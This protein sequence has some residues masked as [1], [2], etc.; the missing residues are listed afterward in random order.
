MGLAFL[1]R[2]WAA[3]ALAVLVGALLILPPLWAKVGLGI[4]LND[5]LN[6]RIADESYYL[7]RIRDVLDGYPLSGNPY[8]WEGKTA[9]PGQP[10]FL[11]EYLSA[12]AIR[13]TGLG[14]VAGSVVLDAILPLV[15]VLL[16]YACFFAA[17]R[18]RALS[19]FG[20]AVLLFWFFPGDFA[21]TVSPQLNFLFWLTQFLLLH[22]IFARPPSPRGRAILI[23]AAAINFGLLFY[24]YTYYWTFWLA[25]LGILSVA[26][27][28]RRDRSRVAVILKIVFGGLVVAL[29]YLVTMV[30]ILARP[31]YGDTVRR[32]GMIDSHFPSGI[33][34]VLPAFLLLGLALL[35][36]WRRVV[37]WD[38]HTLFFVVGAL[39]SVASVNQH[40]VTGKN[41][42]FSSH[43]FM[44]AAFWFVFFGAY[45]VQGVVKSF[46]HPRF[47]AALAGIATLIIVGYAITQSIPPVMVWERGE[48]R[49]YFPLMAWLRENTDRDDVVLAPLEMSNFIPVYTA[50]NV[51]FSSWLRVTFMSDEELL[52]R[53]AIQ[54]NAD[55]GSW[56]PEDGV[57]GVFGVQYLDAALHTAQENR[58][59]KFIGLAPKP[60]DPVP[61]AAVE[62]I[63]QRVD[64]LGGGR[65]RTAMARYRVDYAVVD[66]AGRTPEGQPFFGEPVYEQGG[67]SVYQL[68]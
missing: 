59:R 40:L 12:E 28:L 35:L 20:T 56:E 33:A 3:G 64:E 4:D 8:A 16:T 41:V 23:A 9:F 63:R 51:L 26:A 68:R 1:R 32:I 48:L 47:S 50:N 61:A 58:V 60:T 6:I 43:Y 44:L 49:R 2:H 15:A 57:K 42:E 52:D 13:L 34:I 18:V 55:G 14:V 25:F 38:Q 62:R 24:L 11:G 37:A 46:M 45:L 65:W 10:V 27:F 31:E 36:V 30:R 22:A 19:L 66:A 17:T 29:P 39:A 7:A 67:F 53:F 5:P 21:R 54:V